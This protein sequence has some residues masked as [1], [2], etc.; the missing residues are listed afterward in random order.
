MRHGPCLVGV[1][2]PTDHGMTSNYTQTYSIVTL[3]IGTKRLNHV[4]H[5]WCSYPRVMMQA[6]VSYPTIL[7]MLHEAWTMSDVIGSS[8]RQRQDLQLHP[9]HTHLLPKI[10]ETRAWTMDLISGVVVQEW[11]RRYGYA[12]Q[13]FMSVIWGMDHVWQGWITP[14]IRSWPPTTPQAY[15][16]VT[17]D[18]GIKSL[19]SVM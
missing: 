3:D 2:H 9:I 10:L 6:E 12:I 5:Q 17:L 8:H 15:S 4:P 16:A 13:P 19:K 11:W 1:D 14:H 7:W 18:I